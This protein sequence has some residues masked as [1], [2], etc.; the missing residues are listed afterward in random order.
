MRKTFAFLTA[1]CL[2]LLAAC[3]AQPAQPPK[4]SVPIRIAALKGPT[5]MGMVKLMEEE[6]TEKKGYTFTLAGSPDAITGGI[7]QGEYDIAA[8]PTNLAAVLYNATNAKIKLAALNTLGVLYI[9][10]NGD[11]IQSVGDLKG[12]TIYVSGQGATPEYALNYILEKNGLTPGVDVTIEYRSE[13]A[14]LAALLKQGK[15]EIALLPQPF[16]TTVL[17]QNEKVR[18][19]LDMTDEWN[20]VAPDSVLT[21]GG[22]IV[23]Q[24]FAEEHPE[25]LKGF[26]EEYKASVTYTNK[27]IEEAAKLCEKFDIL[28]ADAAKEAIPF[29]NIVYID[30]EQMKNAVSGYFQVLFDANP[31]SVGEKL[32]DETIYYLP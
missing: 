23:Q 29:C 11:A 31:K 1:A 21:M 9:V 2:L 6:E 14:E 4:E 16:V 15:A 32:P 22:L 26:L 19:A 28:K 20:K 8:V 17:A 25:A 5:A 18:I 24:K 30:G 27:N 10:E 7:I 13:H 3:G 12:K